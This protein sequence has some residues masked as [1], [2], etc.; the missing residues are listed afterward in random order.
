MSV[1]EVPRPERSLEGL[2]ELGQGVGIHPRT[3]IKKRLQSSAIDTGHL[4]GLTDAHVAE[5]LPEVDHE[6]TMGL[7]H[8]VAHPRRRPRALG[9]L[10]GRWARRAGHAL[11]VDDPRAVRRDAMPTP[12]LLAT[13]YDIRGGNYSQPSVILSVR[14]RS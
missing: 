2:L 3:P 8:G 7:V 13:Q 6:S 12:V 4:A 14:V 1:L 5:G 11:T 9:A 10:I